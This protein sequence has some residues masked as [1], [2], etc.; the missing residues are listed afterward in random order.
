[1]NI[2]VIDRFKRH[3]KFGFVLQLS[4]PEDFDYYSIL[5]EYPRNVFAA[6]FQTWNLNFLDSMKNLFCCTQNVLPNGYKATTSLHTQ[7][8]LRIWKLPKSVSLT[9]KESRTSIYLNRSKIFQL[10]FTS[11]TKGKQTTLVMRTA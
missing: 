8:L 10:N 2:T 1:M 7:L 6:N 9:I 3:G 11:S 5:I 4:V